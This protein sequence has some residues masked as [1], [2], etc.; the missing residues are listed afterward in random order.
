MA[1]TF[2]TGEASI[3]GQQ[4]SAHIYIYT[5]YTIKITHY[6]PIY[7]YQLEVRVNSPLDG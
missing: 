7:D 2:E 6:Y 1:L 3:E 5:K 4:N